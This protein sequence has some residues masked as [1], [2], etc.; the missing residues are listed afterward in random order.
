[1][2]A[3]AMETFLARLYTDEAFRGAFLAEPAAVAR[4]EGLDHD[5]VQALL[6]IDRAGLHLAAESYAA[7]RA[8]HAGKPGA[9]RG[10]RRLLKRLTEL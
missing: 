7:K 3:A 1:M 8:A 10:F 2:S 6:R 9:K 4:R 5:A